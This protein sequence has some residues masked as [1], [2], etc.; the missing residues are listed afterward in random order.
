WPGTGDALPMHTGGG[1]QPVHAVLHPVDLC[2]GPCAIRLTARASGTPGPA[3]CQERVRDS[4]HDIGWQ[5]EKRLAIFASSCQELSH[6]VSRNGHLVG[7]RSS[8]RLQRRIA[9]AH[10]RFV[11]EL[12]QQSEQR[13]TAIRDNLALYEI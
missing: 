3:P 10:L 6:A 1:E 11:L 13:S 12:R 9:A 4:L 7:E 2:S 5:H 8:D